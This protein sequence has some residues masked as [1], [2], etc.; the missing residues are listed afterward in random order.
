MLS[1]TLQ[2]R[3]NHEKKPKQLYTIWPRIKIIIKYTLRVHI[4]EDI[5]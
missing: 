3:R 2:E 4:S 1:K 5:F